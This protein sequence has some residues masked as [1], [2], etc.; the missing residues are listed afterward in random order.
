MTSNITD[1]L[2]AALK[3]QDTD[4]SV[5][6]YHSRRLAP[7]HLVLVECVKALELAGDKACDYS[8]IQ[9]RMDN[10]VLLQGTKHADK[11]SRCEALDRL[12]EVLS[13]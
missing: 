3:F 1:K 5:C 10:G 9:Q 11:C 6:N 2:T 12:A 4:C 13:K 7:L 8:I